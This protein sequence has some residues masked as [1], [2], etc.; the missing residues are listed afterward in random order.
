MGYSE[1]Y[2]CSSRSGNYARAV[3][4]CKGTMCALCG[5]TEGLQVHHL[6]LDIT[7]N[8]SLNLCRVCKVH[9]ALFH[10]CSVFILSNPN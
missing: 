9:H 7:N 4:N 1:D 6:D 10:D 5:T 3:R 2:V 8:Q